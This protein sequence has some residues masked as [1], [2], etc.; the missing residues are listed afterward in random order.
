MALGPVP[1]GDCVVTSGGRLPARYVI[2]P[3]QMGQD[4]VTSAEVIERATSNALRAA[5]AQ[6]MTSIA[7]PA[8]GTGVGGF[9][10]SDCARIMMRAVRDRQPRSVRLVRFV[11]FG[12]HA[13][14]AFAEVASHVFDAA[15]TTGNPRDPHDP[16]DLRDPRDPS[17]PLDLR[18]PRGLP[19]PRDPRDPS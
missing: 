13:F 1:P 12:D 19:D 6:G 9:P 14:R 8:F 4:L 11:L 17:D 18:D 5:D 16:R 3:A 10:L 15:R 2:H 7:F